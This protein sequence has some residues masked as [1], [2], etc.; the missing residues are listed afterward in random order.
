[1]HHFTNPDWLDSWA[2]VQRNQSSGHEGR[3]NYD[4]YYKGIVQD[5]KNVLELHKQDTATMFGIHRTEEPSH[6]ISK[7]NDKH[8]L[9]E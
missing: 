2:Y 1:M 3:N 5:A 4:C 9:S 6:S 8:K 7:E